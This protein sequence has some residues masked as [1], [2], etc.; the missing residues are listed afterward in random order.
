DFVLMA[1]PYTLLDQSSLH[2]DMAVCVDR[3]VG[4]VVGSPLASGILA[5]GAR[6]SAKYGYRAAP[7]EIVGKVEAIDSVCRSHG[8]DL[9]AVALQFVLAHPAVVS[10]IPGATRP[11]EIEQNVAS[12]QREIP[13]VLWEELRTRGLI[14]K[15]APV[16]GTHELGRG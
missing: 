12:V 15:D 5:T 1:M 7:P 16:L 8:V 14:E 6:T 2:T 4:V 13:A 9:P 11:E 3:G 10:V